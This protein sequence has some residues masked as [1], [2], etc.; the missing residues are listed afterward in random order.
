MY[1]EIAGQ[2]PVAI[3]KS[4]EGRS[5]H[6]IKEKSNEL[7]RRYALDAVYSLNELGLQSFPM[8]SIGKI[9]KEALRQ[10]VSKIRKMTQQPR[11]PEIKNEQNGFQPR[12]VS[13][14]DRLLDIWQ[15]LVGTRP[16]KSDSVMYFADSITLLRYCENVLRSCGGRLYLQDFVENDTV[17][18]QAQLLEV[19]EKQ[20]A[21]FDAASKGVLG[22][23]ILSKHVHMPVQKSWSWR[24]NGDPPEDNQQYSLMNKDR[25]WNAAELAVLRLG[26]NATEIEDILTIRESLHQTVVGQRPQSFQNRVAFRIRELGKVQILRGL[27]KALTSRPLMRTI[28]VQCGSKTPYHVVLAPSRNLFLR[29]IHEFETEDEEAAMQ[30]VR[31]DS[32]ARHITPF[33]FQADL[34]KIGDGTEYCLAM[35]FSHSIIDAISLS[36]WHRELDRLIVNPEIEIPPLTPYKFFSDLFNRYECS[37]PAQESVKFHVKRL[38]G[39]SRFQR[40]L[41]PPQRAPGWMV[42]NDEGS[43]H[44]NERRRIRNNVWHGQWESRAQ[45]FQYPRCCRALWLPALPHLKEKHGVHPSLLTQYALFIFNV[46]Q[47]GSSHAILTVWESGRSW[48]F[49]PSW[50]ESLLPPAMSIDGPTTEWILNMVEVMNDETIEEFFKRMSLEQAENRRHQHAPWGQV[51]QGLRDEGQVAVDASYRQAFAWDMSLGMSAARTS[52]IDFAT[53][54]PRARYGWADK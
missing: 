48:P 22:G 39:I 40:A 1:D 15:K 25:V 20:Q 19:R 53:L 32:P 50:M 8:T 37:T 23:R 16:S 24:T 27:E 38:R 51:V 5:K 3:V 17:E 36:H 43:Q 41:W 42:S 18:K 21:H 13:L 46:L 54:E 44:M 11:A 26:F 4:L 29:L 33:M 12:T 14:A 7:G 34:T 6:E 28:I 47:T 2:V 52:R 10:T 9:K 45:E 49:V 35:N 31:D 30:M